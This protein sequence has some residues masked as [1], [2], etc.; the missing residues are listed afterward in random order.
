MEVNASK[1]HAMVMSEGENCNVNIVID[2]NDNLCTDILKT[3]IS[4]H[5]RI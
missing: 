2:D 3:K 1:F 5:F 4:Y